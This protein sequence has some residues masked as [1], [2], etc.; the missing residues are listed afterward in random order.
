MLL[1][2]TRMFLLMTCQVPEGVQC[3]IHNSSTG[4]LQE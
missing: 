3:T 4:W 1:F 2:N